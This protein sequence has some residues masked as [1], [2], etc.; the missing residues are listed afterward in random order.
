MEGIDQRGEG[1]EKRETGRRGALRENEKRCYF[2]VQ[3]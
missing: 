1:L 3:K 2:R